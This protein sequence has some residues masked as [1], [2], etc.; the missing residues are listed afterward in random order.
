MYESQLSQIWTGGV[1]IPTALACLATVSSDNFLFLVSDHTILA[2]D[3]TGFSVTVSLDDVTALW[4]EY[5]VPSPILS[6]W[7]ERLLRTCVFRTCE[8]R[9][10]GLAN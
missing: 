8:A 7:G 2:V 9:A 10:S 6:R 5:L 3:C 1:R 4:L